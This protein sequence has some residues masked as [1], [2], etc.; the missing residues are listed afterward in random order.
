VF[1]SPTEI[2][3]GLLAKKE[4][5]YVVS[6]ERSGT[7][8]AIN[9]LFRN[10]YI[11]PRLR[12]VGD[13]LGP[14]DRPETRY[15][16]L[17]QFLRDWPAL[18]SGGGIIKTHADAGL[19]RRWYPSAPVVYVLRDPRD[20]LVSFFHYLNS[21]ELHATNP[22]LENQRCSVFSE[23]LRRPLSPYLRDGFC[24][25]A[26]FENVA[27]RWASH[28]AGWLREPNVCVLRYEDLLR[29]YRACVRKACAETGIVPRLFQKPVGLHDAVSVLPRRGV[30][31]EG[32][33][34]F[35]PDDEQLLREELAARGLEAKDHGFAAKD[36]GHPLSR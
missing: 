33:V 24:E 35:A 11:Q 6:H 8:L 21:D 36:P 2:F 17:E 25:D 20:T 3:F 32:R 5:F 28:V 1:P 12:Y 22:G 27:G 19:F 26:T 29:D 31:G 14:Y 9:T 30:S 4:P 10:A 18:A 13:W 7:H 34:M 23:F 15:R 16:H